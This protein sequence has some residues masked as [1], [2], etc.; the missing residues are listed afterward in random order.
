MKNADKNIEV[1]ADWR[2]MNVPQKIGV[3]SSFLTRGKEIFSFEYDEEWL[4]GSFPFQLDPKIRLFKGSQYAPNDRPNFGIFLDSSPDRWGRTLM[5]RREAVLA[6]QE[7]RP[8]KTLLESDYLVGVYDGHR[9]GGL[10]FKY[11]KGP[12]LD[13]QKDNATPP[14]TSL[15]ELQQASLSLENVDSKNDQK[16]LAW[17]K[18]LVAPG[19]SLGGTRPKASVVDPKRNL[20][21]AKFPSQADSKNVGAWEFVVYSLAKKCGIT[22]P[23]FALE[24]FGKNHHTF[25]SKRFDRHG[26]RK[27]IHFA[28]AMTL[29]EHKD[30][31]DA[32]GGASYLELVDFIIANGAN[33]S[34]D[35]EELWRRI[36]FFISVSNSDDHLRNH[37]FLLSANGWELSPAYDMNPNE[38]ATGLSLNISDTSNALD[39]DLAMDVV[40]FFRIE[41]NRAHD[42]LK[43]IH[44][45]VSQW[46]GVALKFGINKSEQDRMSQ[47]FR[48]KT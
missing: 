15:R 6:R 47:A 9:M 40:G 21:I 46:R 18:L 5:Q 24:R 27:R 26:S 45:E 35:L 2:D 3:L 37:G 7:K 17:L 43:K 38:F 25:L 48:F 12:F 22:V 20:W 34:R 28:S 30:G 1:W 42:I 39:F 13:D 41:I 36:V 32:T 23:E 14:W 16:M 4:R 19:S 8:V 31:D 44:K 10:R 11:E 29:L 33:V